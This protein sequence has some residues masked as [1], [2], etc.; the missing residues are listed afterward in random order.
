MPNEVTVK[1]EGK[2]TVVH[3]AGEPITWTVNAV[4]VNTFAQEGWNDGAPPEGWDFNICD[5]GGREMIGIDRN[6]RMMSGDTITVVRELVRAFILVSAKDQTDGQILDQLKALEAVT[7]VSPTFEAY[8]YLVE[9]R[10]ED[11]QEIRE[12]R[13]KIRRIKEVTAILYLW[14]LKVSPILE[15]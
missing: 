1:F 9:A 3:F 11:R 8:E 12:I 15:T 14:E 10:S 13:G 6:S 7:R 5:A 2:T 4:V